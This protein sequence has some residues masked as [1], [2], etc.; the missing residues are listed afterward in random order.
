[1]ALV[2]CPDCSKEVSSQA[3]TC[4]HCGHLG[5]HARV[6]RFPRGDPTPGRTEPAAGA[7]RGGGQ[8]TSTVLTGGGLCFASLRVAERSNGRFS[9]ATHR[10]TPHHYDDNRTVVNQGKWARCQVLDSV[11]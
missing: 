11:C 4:P 9:G 6:A 10:C 7:A 2:T 8:L 3:P 1:M 5:G